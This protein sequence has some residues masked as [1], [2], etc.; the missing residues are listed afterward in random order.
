MS[1][2]AV[3]YI[4]LL[5][6]ISCS[7]TV[8]KQADFL[9]PDT[10]TDPPGHSYAN[11]AAIPLPEGFT[12]TEAAAG[13]YAAWLRQLSLKEDNTVYL[14]NGAAKANQS[15][16]FAVLDVSVG[17]KDLQQ[18]AD[19]VMRLRAEYLYARRQY[20]AISFTDNEG[21]V[22]RFDAPYTRERFD[23]Y[24]QRVFGM[25][26]SASLSKQL[27]HI[28]IMDMQ[29][30]DVLIKGGFPGHAVIVTDMA[31]NSKGEKLYLL[32]Q[33]YMPAQDIHILNNPNSENLSPWY[34]LSED[35]DIYTPEYYFSS[36]QL[37]T[38]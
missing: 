12:R 16:Q 4:I 2:K 37:K 17:N 13:S 15:A 1:V 32:A 29:P 28:P 38:W 21:T 22:Y 24:L 34:R 9:A 23:A 33:S 25:C 31:V 8:S 10:H 19:A 27:K 14:Y 7:G 3:V 5:A 18:C 26:G 6:C 35:R 20:D 30:G 36:D 11:I